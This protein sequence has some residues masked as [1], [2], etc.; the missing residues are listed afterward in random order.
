MTGRGYSGKCS[1]VSAETK[2]DPIDKAAAL[3]YRLARVQLDIAEMF[4]QLPP[5]LLNVIK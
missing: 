3:A 1:A 5:R 2:C 4:V